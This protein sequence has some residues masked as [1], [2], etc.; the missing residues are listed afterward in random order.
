MI[1]YGLFFFLWKRAQN[2]KINIAVFYIIFFRK[3]FDD[4]KL[5]YRFMLICFFTIYGS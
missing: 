1:G 3:I 5:L 2:I 4:R